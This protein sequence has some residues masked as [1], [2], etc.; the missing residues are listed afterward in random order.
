MRGASSCEGCP[1]GYFSSV[2]SATNS[3]VCHVCGVGKY[4]LGSFCF[5]C[6][7]GSYSSAQG[8]SQCDSC[9]TGK[10]SSG[11]Y[12]SVCEDCI[13]GKY[14]GPWEFQ[15]NTDRTMISWNDA[16]QACKDRGGQLASITSLDESDSLAQ[17]ISDS[18]FGN[19]IDVWIGFYFDPV[20]VSWVW[21][22]GSLSNFSNWGHQS[23]EN[24]FPSNDFCAA[25]SYHGSPISQSANGSWLK[26]NCN[27][28]GFGYVCKVS[29]I[30]ECT[31]C[32]AGKYLDSIGATSESACRACDT[33]SISNLSSSS[34]Q[35]CVRG[36]YAIAGDSECTQC[37][38]GKWQAGDK[39]SNC[40]LCQDGT[41]STVVG[42]SD[43]NVCKDCI[44]GNV[45]S[46][47][48][49]S[50]SPCPAGSF[51]S[52]TGSQ[53]CWPCNAGQYTP[54]MGR[55]VCD[56][57]SGGQYTTSTSMRSLIFQL[58]SGQSWF[59][60]QKRCAEFGGRLATIDSQETNDHVKTLIQGNYSDNN[61]WVGYSWEHWKES[62][63]AGA[64]IS[65]DLPNSTIYTD[66]T[67]INGTT[68]FSPLS[69]ANDSC[70]LIQGSIDP[71]LDNMD[72]N[73]TGTPQSM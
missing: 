44:L 4:A 66:W 1:P 50:C 21:V 55:T 24:I 37:E 20:R 30:S 25:V 11:S 46:A 19:E 36:E 42:G 12:A 52:A 40:N 57:C 56:V 32:A 72:I 59:E 9:N 64:W 2:V 6:N 33:G 63:N 65:G 70:A 61:F 16:Q 47:S 62:S 43:P 7:A 41:Y 68:S 73:L 38:A 27:L 71:E 58:S 15:L 67:N 26:L 35:D 39:G 45:L 23:D 8:L 34:C 29:A 14:S 54:H 69:P 18:F 28:P 60:A 48:L 31:S 5:A 22:D 10:Y 53:A 3:S 13:A 17:Y 51:A 49:D